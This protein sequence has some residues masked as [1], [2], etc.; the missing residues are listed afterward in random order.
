MSLVRSL[1]D[2]VMLSATVVVDEGEAR[3]EASLCAYVDVVSAVRKG[4]EG[5]YH[6]QSRLIGCPTHTHADACPAY[7]GEYRVKACNDRP[8]GDKKA[9][10]VRGRPRTSSRRR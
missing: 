9:W 5:K 1:R 3:K 10:T 4:V 8:E 6:R 7:L 2:W